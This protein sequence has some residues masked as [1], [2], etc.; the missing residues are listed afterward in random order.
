MIAVNFKERKDENENKN[1]IDAKTPFHQIST[2]IFQCRV[3][4]IIE[5]KKNK[6]A[7]G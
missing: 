3:L 7:K 1:I 6:K 5:K 4:G 2:D